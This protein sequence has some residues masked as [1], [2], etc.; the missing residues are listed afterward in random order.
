MR[1]IRLR[2]PD[3]LHA[4]MHQLASLAGVPV[5]AAYAILALDATDR[6]TDQVIVER[7]KGA[8]HFI[9]FDEGRVVLREAAPVEG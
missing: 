5:S 3:Q 6:Y 9:Q 8:S 4:K 7:L 2:V 1:D